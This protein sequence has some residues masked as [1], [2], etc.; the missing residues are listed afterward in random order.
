MGNRPSAGIEYNSTAE[1]ILAETAMKE[2]AENRNRFYWATQLGNHDFRMLKVL[3]SG[4]FDSL[5]ECNIEVWHLKTII[6][7]SPAYKAVSSRWSDHEKSIGEVILRSGS[8]VRRQPVLGRVEDILRRI[9]NT[10]EPVYV[11]I[12]VLC[13]MNGT[14]EPAMQNLLPLI[15][16]RANE[17]VIWLGKMRPTRSGDERSL[18]FDFVPNLCRLES[19]TVLQTPSKI[20]RHWNGFVDLLRLPYFSRR[21]VFLEI[22]LSTHPVLYYGDKRI[23]WMDFC[24]AVILLGSQFEDVESFLLRK[25][26]GYVGFEYDL[27]V[28]LFL[29]DLRALP[30]YS[31]VKT[32]R[33]LFEKEVN[34]TFY[35]RTQCSLESL[36]S[37]LPA[38]QSTDAR[39]VVNAL[40]PIATDRTYWEQTIAGHEIDSSL[41]VYQLFVDYCVNKSGS[42]DIICRP[43]APQTE[44]LPSW[45]SRT[46]ALPF[47]SD[48]SGRQNGE[49]F[50][51]YP[52]RKRYDAS[53]AAILKSKHV[54][55]FGQPSPHGVWHLDGSITVSGFIINQINERTEHAIRMGTLPPD[56]I[57]LS[58][59]KRREDGSSCANDNLWRTLVADRGPD[60]IPAPLWYGQAC[61]Y[62][63]D[64]S[65]GKSIDMRIIKGK[66]HPTMALEYIKRVRSVIWNRVMFV[67]KGFS[68]SRL[69][70]L[71]PAKAQIGDTICI[72]HGC[73]VP[74][75]LRQLGTQ[76]IWEIVGE[77]FVYSLMDGEAMSVDNIK[78]T[79]EF[80]I[81]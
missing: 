52:F 1:D 53:R 41:D 56:W 23:N 13:I 18:A 75:L 77:C 51:G 15:F 67:T 2:A 4:D 81:K 25:T 42:L 79:R 8:L 61:Q 46:D 73:S 38:L 43:W 7:T 35:P 50:V 57:R 47:V 55:I 31:V 48:K 58:G 80:V 9:R 70:G 16:R 22:I 27:Y 68:G 14:E 40:A 60:G 21:W 44:T 5:V 66:Q 20:K 76:D 30:A 3:P 32:S 62:W 63:L 26:L 49:V 39:D 17:T 34:G 64:I 24:D 74:V 36:V 19:I 65:N 69:L 28:G 33:E 72:L 71:G 59:G 45:I 6:D 78:A 54:A 37:M 12:G 10:T 11:W 29:K